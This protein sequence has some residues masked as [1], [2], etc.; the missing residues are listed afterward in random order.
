MKPSAHGLLPYA[1]PATLEQGDPA[2]TT[3]LLERLV[4]HLTTAGAPALRRLGQELVLDVW[5]DTV[6]SF[7]DPASPQRR[8][9]DATL[10]AHCRLSPAGLDAA[11]EA[12]LQGVARKPAAALWR[13]ASASGAAGAAAPPVWVV[14]AS[15]LPALAVQPLLTALASGRPVVLKSPSSEPWFAPHFVHALRAREPSLQNAVAALTWRGGDRAL[16]EP[17]LAGCD[18]I[19]AYG[20]ATTLADLRRRAGT[21]RFVGHGPKTS[22]AIISREA[23]LPHVA[24]GLARD[25]ALFDQRG[26][27][28]VAA[29]YTDG[30][31]SNLATALADAL[32]G[33]AVNLPPG[34]ADVTAAGALQQLRGEAQMRG[35][36]GHFLALSS[37]T[38]VVEDKPEFHPSPGLRTVRIHPVTSLAS[39]PALLAPWQGQLQGAALAGAAAWELAAPLRPLG[40]TRFA[41][42]GELQLPDASWENEAALLE[43]LRQPTNGH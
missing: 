12:V 29:V 25:I 10:T 23:D 6:E 37:G 19:V 20:E 22:L 14:L 3:V 9:L 8:Q 5:A 40:F 11:L 43:A 16:E 24:R 7:R 38:V 32:R 35:L 21:R 41:K 1:L 4:D 36:E 27:L 2:T 17:L 13:R 31:A 39:I 42:A 18:P 30:S 28:S 15:N 26:C 34:P 33:E